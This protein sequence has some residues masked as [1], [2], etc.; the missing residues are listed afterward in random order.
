MP[1]VVEWV[2]IATMSSLGPYPFAIKSYPTYQ[3]C[4]Q[5]SQLVDS[6]VVRSDCARVLVPEAIANRGNM[7]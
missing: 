5:A 2:L 7:K 3:Q 6:N 1:P 4:V